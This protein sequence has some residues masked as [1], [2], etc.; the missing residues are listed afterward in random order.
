MNPEVKKYLSELG[1]KGGSAKSPQ[2]TEACRANA[3]LPRKK[4]HEQ[5]QAD[6]GNQHSV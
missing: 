6:T 1:K 2:K 5:A 4:K 3:R